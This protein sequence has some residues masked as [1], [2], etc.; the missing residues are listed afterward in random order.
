M[1]DL[2]EGRE[3]GPRGRAVVTR[4]VTIR[5]MEAALCTLGDLTTEDHEELD[6][7]TRDE[8]SH[9]IDVLDRLIGERRGST[10]H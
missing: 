1:Q 6:G 2:H 5:R 8:I 4:R 3:Q 7:G 10:R 9:V